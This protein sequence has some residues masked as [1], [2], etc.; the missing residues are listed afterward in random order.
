MPRYLESYSLYLLGRRYRNTSGCA[1]I[2][3]GRGFV[4]AVDQE[5]FD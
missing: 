2:L 3:G 5:R 4:V 1:E